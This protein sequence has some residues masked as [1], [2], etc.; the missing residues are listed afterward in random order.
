MNDEL[1]IDWLVAKDAL[2]KAK[3]AEA[4]LRRMVVEEHFNA[5]LPGINKREDEYGIL[6]VTLPTTYSLS[7]DIPVEWRDDA[8]FR[9]KMELDKRRY[10]KLGAEERAELDEYITTRHGTPRVEYTTKETK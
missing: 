8:L 6:K 5:V 3:H 9:H 1:I 4:R 10:E 7:A 2:A